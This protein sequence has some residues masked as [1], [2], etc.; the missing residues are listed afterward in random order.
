MTNWKIDR[1]TW[2]RHDRTGKRIYRYIVS[3]NGELIADVWADSLDLDHALPGDPVGNARK[4][5]AVP[6]MLRALE[7][8]IA[9]ADDLT[10]AIEGA[11][12]QFEDEVSRLCDAVSAAERVL[13]AARGRQ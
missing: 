10:A 4:I 12:D 11:T 5:A 9:R 7:A 6:R 1:S 3:D 2:E 8:L 13:I